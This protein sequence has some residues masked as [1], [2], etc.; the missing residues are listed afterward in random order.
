MTGSPD[1]TLALEEARR[2][3]DQQ[4]DDF[5][6]VRDRARSALGTGGLAASFLGG[7]TIRDDTSLSR[8][9]WMAVACFCLLAAICLAIMWPREVWAS[10][11]PV[12]LVR[13]TEEYEATR[14]QMTRDLAPHLG[15]QVTHNR[16][17]LSV[18]TR[19]YP[20]LSRCSSWSSSFSSLT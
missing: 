14:A 13:W 16:D 9:T 17:Q 7:L 1:Y 2:G 5:S 10:Q 12:T 3:F 4:A 15:Q 20:G 11:S 19:L 8:W 18:L 6:T